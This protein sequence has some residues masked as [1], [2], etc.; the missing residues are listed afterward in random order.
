MVGTVGIGPGQAGRSV[1]GLEGRKL[2]RIL[3]SWLV[4]GLLCLVPSSTEAND[5]TIT[6][7]RGASVTA[8]EGSVDS[9]GVTIVYHTVGEGPLV[10]FVHGISGPWFDFR[11][12]MVML[13]EQ[14]RVVAMSTR[15]TNQSDKPV[16]SEH[17]AS[18]RISDDITAIIDHF[19]EE[20]A[21]VIGQ[22]SGGCTPG[23]SR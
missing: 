23:I 14:Y 8:T 2:V 17:Y 20:R 4:V 12:Q 10:I 13:S 19:G 9:S 1:R 18:A 16:G 15:G 22:D 3:Y 5:V 11:H 7:W 21:T 6:D